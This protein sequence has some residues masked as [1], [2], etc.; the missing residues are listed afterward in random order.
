LR[1]YVGNLKPDFT[2]EELHKLFSD[3]GQVESASIVR[4]RY[5]EQSK[6]FAFV[7][8]PSGEEAQAAIIA[9]NGSEVQ[10]RILTVSLARP[11]EERGPGT[12]STYRPS[13]RNG[14]LRKDKKGPSKRTRKPRR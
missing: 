9:L 1:L 6:G 8:M 12:G 11:K 7:D 5:S 14:P 10:Q 13:F 4:D 2:D 3:H